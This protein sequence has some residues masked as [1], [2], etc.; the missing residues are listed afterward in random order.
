MGN[1]VKTS[2]QNEEKIH[3]T[4]QE[5][6]IADLLA[7]GMSEKEIADELTCSPA[8]VNNHTRNIRAKFGV[9]K[10]SEII[11]AFIADLKGKPF[12]IANIR[13]Y[14]ISIILVMLNICEFNKGF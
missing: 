11:L 14:G 3:F 8:T 7:R 5:R 4:K 12:N 1:S 13:K 2:N 10:N 6:K 9:N